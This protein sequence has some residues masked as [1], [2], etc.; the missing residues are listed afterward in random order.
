MA[1]RTLLASVLLCAGTFAAA[2]F[3]PSGAGS[4]T[5]SDECL[6]NP[7]SAACQTQGMNQNQTSGSTTSN[8]QPGNDTSFDTDLSG[9]RSAQSEAT[10]TNT[11][12]YDGYNEQGQGA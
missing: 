3:A 7:N 9:T 1:I 6:I 5:T 8:G 2:Q 12:L 11:N 10:P 4:P